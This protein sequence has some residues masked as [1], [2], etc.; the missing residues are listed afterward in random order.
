MFGSSQAEGIDA[1]AEGFEKDGEQIRILKHNAQLALFFF[2]NGMG[3]DEPFQDSDENG[4]KWWML[5]SDVKFGDRS[6]CSLEPSQL[7]A[8]T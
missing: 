6:L 3:E 2:A 4:G 5:V 8:A 7:A 1:M